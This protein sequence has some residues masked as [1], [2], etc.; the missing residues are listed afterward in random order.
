MRAKWE[1]PGR[2]SRREQRG[3][4]ALVGRRLQVL[5]CARLGTASAWLSAQ[6]LAGK[7]RAGLCRS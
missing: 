1:L 2:A 3:R 7:M 6:A 4:A 5:A